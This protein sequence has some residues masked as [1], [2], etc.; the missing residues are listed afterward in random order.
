MPRKETS[1]I[2]H[3]ALDSVSKIFLVAN[4]K[5][6]CQLQHQD[7]S[8]PLSI[9]SQSLQAATKGFAA[10]KSHVFGEMNSK[11]PQSAEKLLHRC[12]GNWI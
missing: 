6:Q 3:K 11:S 5:T 4:P 8:L 2:Q 9:V 1:V 12:C 7:F 10:T